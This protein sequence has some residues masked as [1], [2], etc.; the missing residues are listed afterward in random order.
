MADVIHSMFDYTQR[1][2]A[3]DGDVFGGSPLGAYELS[4]LRGSLVSIAYNFKFL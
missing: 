3:Q 4:V 1:N 2:G